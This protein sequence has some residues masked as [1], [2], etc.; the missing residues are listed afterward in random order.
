MIL[1]K[2]FKSMIAIACFV[3]A[4]ISIFCIGNMIWVNAETTEKCAHVWVKG[5][6]VAPTCLSDG[7]TPS[8]CSVCHITTILPEDRVAA[9]G[10][11]DYKE[12]GSSELSCITAGYKLYTCSTCGDTNVE[13]YTPA[14]GHT[15]VKGETVAPTCL[16][17]GYTPST[18]T[19]CQA[20][21]IFPEDRVTAVGAHDYE[22]TNNSELSCI[23]A[24]YKLYTCKNCGDTNVEGYTPATGHTWVKG[25]T[26]APT[27]ISDGYTTS[28]CSVCQVTTILTEDRVPNFG[29][30]TWG[31]AVVTA[32]TCTES[33]YTSAKCTRCEKVSVTDVVKNTGHIYKEVVSE[34]TC[35]E[36]GRTTYI[37]T[38][39]EYNNGGPITSNPIDHSFGDDNKC[40]VCG[41]SAPD[42][43]SSSASGC[44]ANNAGMYISMFFTVILPAMCVSIGK[45][46]FI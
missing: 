42:S 13:G 43:V 22:E 44:N 41:I 32:P 45:F 26:V 36:A 29:G 19:V 9:V 39:C 20:T 23:T 8:T 11:H 3:L 10:A 21:T 33:G 16:S 17:D 7:Y 28:T 5:E 40:T 31:E 12:T 14:T 25:E 30:H 1:R 34:P 2:S 46:F 15:W 6:T 35:T 38:A 18:C 27:C 4:M 24:G 37:C